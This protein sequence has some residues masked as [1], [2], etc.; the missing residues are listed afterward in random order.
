MV[1]REDIEIVA[2]VPIDMIL[3]SQSGRLL[4]LLGVRWASM[5]GAG[6]IIACDEERLGL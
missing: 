2:A 1:P 6:T 4:C 5:G 3:V